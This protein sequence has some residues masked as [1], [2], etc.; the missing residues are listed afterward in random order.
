MKIIF[1]LE[2]TCWENCDSSQ[3]DQMETIE[4]GAVEVDYKYI[5]TGREYQAFIRPFVNPILT[6]FCTQLTSITQE[7]V[8]SARGFEAVFPEFL[9]WAN[10][11]R[12]QF[13]SWG[14]YDFN[15]LNKDCIRVDHQMFTKALHKNGKEIYKDFTGKFGKALRTELN[16]HN[17]TF[18]GIPHRGIDDAKM[19]AQLLKTAYDISTCPRTW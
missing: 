7:Q 12:T 8:T 15:Q 14:N 11:P 17:L 19:I 4:I 2:A 9:K 6:D 18:E 10:Y 1:D 13:I 16:R 5:P 3:R